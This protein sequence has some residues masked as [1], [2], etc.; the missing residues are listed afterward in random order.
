MQATSLMQDIPAVLS[1]EWFQTLVQGK[2]MHIERIVSKGHC[3]PPGFWYKQE[4]SEWVLL[5][6]GAARL[7]FAEPE[8]EV[9]LRPGMHVN[10]AAHERHRVE[11]TSQDEET[12]WLAV[13]YET[14]NA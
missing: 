10:I 13:F 4:E 14:A 3:S 11:W 7:R 2:G 6:K 9:E 5:V 1:E 12:I 8:R